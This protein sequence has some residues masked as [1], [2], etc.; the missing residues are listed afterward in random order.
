MAISRIKYRSWV[1]T[2]LMPVVKKIGHH[3]NVFTAKIT[4][5]EVVVNGSVK[6][7]LVTSVW[8]RIRLSVYPSVNNQE[9]T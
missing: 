4:I 8:Q 2:S 7:G 3:G 9:D 1:T 5:A 6:V